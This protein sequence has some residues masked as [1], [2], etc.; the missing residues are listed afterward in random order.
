[1][2]APNLALKSAGVVL[3]GA[4]RQ[5]KAL[6]AAKECEVKNLGQVEVLDP[7]LKGVRCP[8]IVA[9]LS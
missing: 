4:L 7:D 5:A 6:A 8:C 2:S 9:Y 1:M 3:A